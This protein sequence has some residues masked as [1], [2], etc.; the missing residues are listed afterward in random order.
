MRRNAGFEVTD[1]INLGIADVTELRPALKMFGD[2]IKNET[3]AVGLDHNV[4]REVSQEWN[5]NGVNTLIAV[6]KI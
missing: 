4:S 1:R 3:L 5:I 6:E 2:Y